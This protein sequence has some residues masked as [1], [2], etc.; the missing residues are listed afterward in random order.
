MQYLGVRIEVEPV[1]VPRIAYKPA[2]GL[3]RLEHERV[4]LR[5]GRRYSLEVD[6]RII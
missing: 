2:E 5:A 6:G 1:P 3:L 4:Y